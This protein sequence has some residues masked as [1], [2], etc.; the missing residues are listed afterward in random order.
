MKYFVFRDGAFEW[1]D[2]LR[3]TDRDCTDLEDAEEA[4]KI[5]DD[6]MLNRSIQPSATVT[7]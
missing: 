4:Q 2:E 7:K 6:W 1:T 5:V 3:P